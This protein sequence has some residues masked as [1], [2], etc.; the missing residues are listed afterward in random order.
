MKEAILL[1]LLI[2]TKQPATDIEC[3]QERVIVQSRPMCQVYATTRIEK[4]ARL[5]GGAVWWQG[6]CDPKSS[7]D[8][9]AMQ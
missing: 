5:T 3:W 2:C 9:E 8:Q 6:W 4:V 7:P 1:V